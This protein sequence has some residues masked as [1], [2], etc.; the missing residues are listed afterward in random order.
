[1]LA[2]GMT[3]LTPDWAIFVIFNM[4]TNAILDLQKFEIFMVSPL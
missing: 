2:M 4:V 3:P 1:M